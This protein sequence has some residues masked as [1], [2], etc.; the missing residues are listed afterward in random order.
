MCEK[1]KG[2]FFYIFSHVISLKKMNFNLENNF[3]TIY[4]GNLAVGDFIIINRNETFPAD[5]LLFDC[6]N[7]SALVDTSFVDGQTALYQK[8]PLKLT[9]SKFNLNYLISFLFSQSTQKFSFERQS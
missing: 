4:F 9:S 1:N 7:D 2:S 5:V 6:E 3:E 8:K